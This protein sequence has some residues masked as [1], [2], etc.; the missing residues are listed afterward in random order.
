MTKLV[1]LSLLVIV[2]FIFSIGCAEILLRL[3]KIRPPVF[4][5]SQNMVRAS[6]NSVLGYELNPDHPEVNSY[7]LKGPELITTKADGAYRLITLGDSVTFG[8]CTSPSLAGYPEA[9]SLALVP[10]PPHSS[11][12]V[13]NAGVVGYNTVQEAEFFETKIKP[14]A[15]DF[16][17]VQVT[18]NDFEPKKYEYDDLI[19][20]LEPEK[21]PQVR[22]FYD[23]LEK[24]KKHLA[25]SVV[26]QEVVYY[27]LTQQTAPAQQN[28]IKLNQNRWQDYTTIQD[29][30]TQL[31]QNLPASLQ[32][33]VLVVL[34]PYFVGDI[35][36][37]PTDL[38]EEHNSIRDSA[39]TL[40]FSFIDL[41]PCF[42]TE[43]SQHH[44]SFQQTKEDVAHP[45]AYGHQIAAHCIATELASNYQF[46]LNPLYSFSAF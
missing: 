11:L 16:V 30:L 3:F 26:F 14:L 18:L 32:N 24:T 4:H 15:P 33:R 1:K 36:H 10:P 23:V 28:Q 38:L 9:L 12:E 42:Q 46:A 29:G 8:C 43:F 27:Y 5:L 44:E 21:Q 41:L 17:I 20:T 6:S 45:N 35:N 37:Y 39:T 31:K 34:F 7:G 19:A 40:G 2:S 22:K 25:K 13:I